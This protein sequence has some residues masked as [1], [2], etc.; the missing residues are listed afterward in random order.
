MENRTQEQLAGSQRQVRVRK[1]NMQCLRPDSDC[2]GGVQGYSALEE[3]RQ[4]AVI[5]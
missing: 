2:A 4:G 5:Q 3:W 1:V